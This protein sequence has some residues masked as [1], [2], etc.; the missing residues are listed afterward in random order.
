MTRQI[1]LSMITGLVVMFMVASAILIFQ[2][3][4]AN[5]QTCEKV[6]DILNRLDGFATNAAVGG[7]STKA[8]LF[9]MDKDEYEVEYDADILYV[10]F[11]DNPN[12]VSF[13]IFVAETGCIIRN[14][15]NP[16]SVTFRVP[17]NPKIAEFI[18]KSDLIYH[19]EPEPEGEPS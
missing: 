12:D 7:V 3:Q 2:T 5:S 4:P 6:E 1:V 17:M 13:H 11:S 14:P 8:F 19:K 10:I 16:N 9:R 18:G 15:A